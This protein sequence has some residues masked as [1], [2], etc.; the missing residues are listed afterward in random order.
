MK[1]LP[2]SGSL[3]GRA[4]GALGR[5]IGALGVATVGARAAGFVEWPA[6]LVGASGV[7]WL[8]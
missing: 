3:A 5:A 4:I 1:G 8:G 6:W 7:G 2:R